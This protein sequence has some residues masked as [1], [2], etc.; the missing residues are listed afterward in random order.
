MASSIPFRMILYPW[1]TNQSMRLSIK[2][3]YYP[4]ALTIISLEKINYQTPF[5]GTI[6]AIRKPVTRITPQTLRDPTRPA[7]SPR[8]GV[9]QATSAFSKITKLFTL[10]LDSLN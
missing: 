8:T 2:A 3:R 7:V 10:N 5:K 4:E 9:A 1:V 6:A